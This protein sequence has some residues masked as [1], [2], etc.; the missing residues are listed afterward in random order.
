MSDPGAVTR[1]EPAW[2]VSLRIVGFLL[3]RLWRMAFALQA[4]CPRLARSAWDLSLSCRFSPLLGDSGWFL[5]PPCWQT[6]AKDIFYNV[7][8]QRF[9]KVALSAQ[10]VLLRLCGYR[11]FCGTPA[12]QALRMPRILQH[13][14]VSGY[15][16]AG[17]FAAFRPLRLHGYHV[18]Y[19]T[20]AS[21]TAR[22]PCI[23]RLFGVS[24]YMDTVCFAVFRILWL[25]GCRLFCSISASWAIWILCILQHSGLSGYTD[26]AYFAAF[27]PLRLYGYCVFCSTSVSQAI[28]I[29]KE[30]SL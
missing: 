14:G 12:S 22:V 9:Q 6:R 30:M 20:P 17:Y 4:K 5:F 23:L 21:Q 10:W 18:F 3:C 26:T 27:R 16:D 24:G 25:H 2:D 28:R 7:Q 19:S 13:F 8:S 15:T 11:V 29:P 1:W